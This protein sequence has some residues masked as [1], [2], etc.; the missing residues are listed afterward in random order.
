MTAEYAPLIPS[1]VALIKKAIDEDP[2]LR[3]RF[4]EAGAECIEGIVEQLLALVKAEGS[5][6]ITPQKLNEY[7]KSGI[8]DLEIEKVRRR[9]GIMETVREK[10]TLRKVD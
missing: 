2:E 3:E 9:W 4:G 10:I 1:I 5:G 7:L 6:N 8:G